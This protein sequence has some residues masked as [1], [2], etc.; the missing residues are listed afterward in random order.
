VAL[1]AEAVRVEAQLAGMGA[2]PADGAL[3]V[4]DLGGEARSPVSRY[5]EAMATKPCSVS[6]VAW[7]ASMSFEPRDPAAAV[8]QQHRRAIAAGHGLIDVELE[9]ASAHV[10]ENHVALNIHRPLLRMG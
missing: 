8:Q 2:D 10:A 6:A 5:S 3:G 1:Q 4:V 7:G 9:R